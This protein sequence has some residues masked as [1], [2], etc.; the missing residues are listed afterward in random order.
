MKFGEKNFGTEHSHTGKSCGAIIREIKATA[1]GFQE[2]EFVHECR[3]SN[4][5]AHVLAKSSLYESIGRH[6]W[7]I[8]PP[9]VSKTIS[10]VAS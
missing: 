2:L 9:G 4:V 5:D 8:D 3:N 6:V 10:I 7:F 1:E